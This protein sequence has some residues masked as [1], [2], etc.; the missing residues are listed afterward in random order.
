LKRRITV[1]E[2]KK[3]KVFQK[4]SNSNL[5]KVSLSERA[6]LYSFRRVPPV[7]S[8]HHHSSISHLFSV[9]VKISP[10]SLFCYHRW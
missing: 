1:T 3:K 2:A 4:P 9:F 6:S 7:N 8:N 10:T 5:W